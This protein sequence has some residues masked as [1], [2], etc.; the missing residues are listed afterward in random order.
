MWK[1]ADLKVLE[2][3]WFQSYPLSKKNVGVNEWIRW[4]F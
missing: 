4:Y 3:L 2:T 1:T